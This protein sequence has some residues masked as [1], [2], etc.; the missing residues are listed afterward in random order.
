[1]SVPEVYPVRLFSR[2]A[3]PK[4]QTHTSSTKIKALKYLDQYNSIRTNLM[5]VF[6]PEL[7]T[8][9]NDKCNEPE[10]IGLVKLISPTD[11]S[12]SNVV[13]LNAGEAALS[14]HQDLIL[15]QTKVPWS[16][17]DLSLA[18]PIQGTSYL[19]PYGF[20]FKVTRYS[21]LVVY[22]KL[23]FSEIQLS[24]TQIKNFCCGSNFILL[25]SPPNH[26]SLEGLLVDNVKRTTPYVGVQIG[27]HHHKSLLCRHAALTSKPK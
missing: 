6:L 23:M 27:M 18:R 8:L 24:S 12:V 15:S 5:L 21:P 1:M 4:Q 3:M 25:H 17:A 26:N 10:E 11:G 13:T 16:K 20:I 19:I 9:V 14:Y 22:Q 2:P 7:S